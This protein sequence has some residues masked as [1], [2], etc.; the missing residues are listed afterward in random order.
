MRKRRSLSLFWAGYAASQIGTSAWR[1]AL[2]WVTLVRTDSVWSLVAVSA[3]TIV[4]ELIFGPLG[5]TLADRLPRLPSLMTMDAGRAALYGIT[6][7]VVVANGRSSAVTYGLTAV[8]ALDAGVGILSTS[9][10]T[11]VLR[12][13]SAHAGVPLKTLLGKDRAVRNTADIVGTGAGGLVVAATSLPV[14]LG[15]NALS[16]LL[17]LVGLSLVRS[18]FPRAER[19]ARPAAGTPDGKSFTWEGARVARRQPLVR[20][21]LSRQLVLNLPMPVITLGFP[22]VLAA[23]GAS[24]TVLGF[25]WAGFSLG[26]LGMSLFTGRREVKSPLL[27]NSPRRGWLI[28]AGA[29]ALLAAA[30][31]LPTPCMPVLL[32]VLGALFTRTLLDANLQW[33]TRLESRLTG[34]VA[35]LAS[36][37]ARLAA[38]LAT[39]AVAAVASRGHESTGLPSTALAITVVALVF[40]LLA[41]RTDAVATPA[42]PGVPTPTRTADTS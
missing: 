36:V 16:F 1:L 20:D 13:L 14:V 29:S 2:P 17:S 22:I 34:R 12:E 8:Q 40:F 9:T 28:T 32:V 39:V 33:Q 6:C 4:P 31:A 5:G 19:R 3:A 38:L 37:L 41:P 42:Q 24:A 25:T 18:L 21:A 30:L 23:R 26:S 27:G 7:L 11:A 35:A 15:A 10:R